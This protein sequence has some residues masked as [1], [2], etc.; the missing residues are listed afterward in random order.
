MPWKDKQKQRDVIKKHY[1]ANKQV[2]I[3]KAIKRKKEVRRW[4]NDMKEASPCSDCKISYPYY[5]MDFDHV[6]P[7][8]KSINAII[9]NSSIRGIKEEIANCELVCS[10]CHRIRT[11]TRLNAPNSQFKRVNGIIIRLSS[12]RSSAD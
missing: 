5:V 12:T 11:H 1:Y 10:N 4:V 2:Y 6:G 3:D 9:D 8:T 7:K